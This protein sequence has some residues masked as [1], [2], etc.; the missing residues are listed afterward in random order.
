MIGCVSDSVS[1]VIRR[2]RIGLIL[3][4]CIVSTG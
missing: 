3:V 1:G 4:V 2:E